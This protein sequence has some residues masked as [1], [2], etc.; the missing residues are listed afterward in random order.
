MLKDIDMTL[1][2]FVKICDR[3]TSKKLFQC[4]VRGNLIKDGDGNLTKVNDD[5]P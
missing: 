3:F 1:D 5:N 4:D 2:E